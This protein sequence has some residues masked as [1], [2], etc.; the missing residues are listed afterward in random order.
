M[1]FLVLWKDF[2]A[3]DISDHILP[4]SVPLKMFAKYCDDS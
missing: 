4:I 2:L 3:V 1:H